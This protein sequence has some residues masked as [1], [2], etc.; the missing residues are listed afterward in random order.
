MKSAHS[1]TFSNEDST[2]STATVCFLK[3]GSVVRSRCWAAALGGGLLVVVVV[4][5]VVALRD[6]VFSCGDWGVCGRE[7]IGDTL[8][9]EEC[10]LH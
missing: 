6:A 10:V 8:L 2:R 7:L 4:L 3:R 9:E 5:A 1:L